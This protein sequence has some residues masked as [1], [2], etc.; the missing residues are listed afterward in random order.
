MERVCIAGGSNT[1]QAGGHGHA[2]FRRGRSALAHSMASWT[3]AL[4]AS[5]HTQ[6][7]FHRGQ[8]GLGTKDTCL[9]DGRHSGPLGGFAVCLLRRSSLD[10]LPQFVADLQDFKNARAPAVACLMASVAALGSAQ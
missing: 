7:F 8:T 10:E 4:T 2:D 3:G 1:N 9:P 5:C 6:H